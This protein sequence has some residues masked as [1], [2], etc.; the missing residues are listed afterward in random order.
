MAAQPERGG[1]GEPPSRR[2][3]A[4]GYFILISGY[5]FRS[6]CSRAACTFPVTFLSGAWTTCLWAIC[7]GKN[8][9]SKRERPE[10]QRAA[11]SSS[12]KGPPAN[13]VCVVVAILRLLLLHHLS[14]LS[15]LSLLSLLSLSLPLKDDDLF[16][17]VRVSLSLSRGRKEGRKERPTHSPL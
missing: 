17:S 8:L 1:G 6:P 2:G 3:L 11:G 9:Q 15:P 5:R 7:I 10:E 13:L 12:L 4:F 16:R 14:S